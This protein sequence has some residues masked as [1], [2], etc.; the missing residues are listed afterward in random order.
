M[1]HNT[2]VR[3]GTRLELT[4]ANDVG[5]SSLMPFLGKKIAL[6][7]ANALAHC[8][9]FT[10][11]EHFLAFLSKKTL[12]V[13]SA[14]RSS[15]SNTIVASY[16]A[17]KLQETF[18]K[19][20]ESKNCTNDEI[21]LFLRSAIYSHQHLLAKMLIDTI[22]KRGV[23]LES[24]TFIEGPETDTLLTYAVKRDNL[25][26]VQLLLHNNRVSVTAK[27][28]KTALSTSELKPIE[29]ALLEK[30]PNMINIAN[31]LLLREKDTGITHFYCIIDLSSA[32]LQKLLFT[33]KQSAEMIYSL[34][35]TWINDPSA[36]ITRKKSHTISGT[37][38]KLEQTIKALLTKGVDVQLLK[39]QILSLKTTCKKIQEDHK[40]YRHPKCKKYRHLIDLLQKSLPQVPLDELLLDAD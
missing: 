31:K 24:L 19:T 23:C 39:T 5:Q 9:F 25:K 27:E 35:Q 37:Q 13:L 32:D 7:V 14:C 16:V 4:T 8:G 11:L 33:K 28:P 21:K 10:S 6:I 17:G 18:H 29:I 30:Q 38:R 15:S 26:A 36:L 34:C 3:S 22:E 40:S 1:V 2:A 12:L 20:I